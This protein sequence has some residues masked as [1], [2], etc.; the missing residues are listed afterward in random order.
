MDAQAQEQHEH[1]ERAEARPD[2]V[3]QV[4]A[5]ETWLRDAAAGRHLGQELVQQPE[6][7]HQA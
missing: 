5:I 2:K 3:A 6:L 7:V 1:R 4:E